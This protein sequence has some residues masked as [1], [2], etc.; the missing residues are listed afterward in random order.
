MPQ[1]GK[2]LS[3]LTSLA[4]LWAGGLDKMSFIVFFQ[5]N[6]FCNFVTSKMPVESG[7]ASPGPAH[8][9]HL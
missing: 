4:L 8:Y 3:S 5:P 1:K 6:L 9:L 2:A 7:A